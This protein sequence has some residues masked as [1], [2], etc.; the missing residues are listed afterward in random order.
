[1]P[2]SPSGRRVLLALLFLL[3]G[4]TSCTQLLGG[5]AEIRQK[6]LFLLEPLPIR[7]SLPESERPYSGLVHLKNFNVEGAYN[8]VKIIN[9]ISPYELRLD[10]FHSWADRP[11]DMVTAAVA[12]YLSQAQLFTQLAR[13]T[14]WLDRPPDYVI[15]GTLEALERIDSNDPWYARLVLSMELEDRDSGQVIWRDQ[16]TT[17]DEL[18]VYNEDMKFTVEAFSQILQRGMEDFIAEIDRI[19][20]ARKYGGA[21]A[22]LSPVR[23]DSLEQ[24][25]SDTTS[26]LLESP[27]YQ[28][29]P[30][31]IAP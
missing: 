11:R 10:P 4:L 31:K 6:R 2:N 1:M 8:Q 9:R 20:L 30:G 7:N 24:I 12:Q 25:S 5:K 15:T 28:I 26:T 16:I 3:L 22:P 14:D 21:G 19:L 13:D 27:Y 18:Q 23:T 17:D 29:I